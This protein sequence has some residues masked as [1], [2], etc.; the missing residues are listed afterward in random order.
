MLCKYAEI[1]ELRTYLVSHSAIEV[2]QNTSILYEY[3][4]TTPYIKNRDATGMCPMEELSQNKDNAEDLM[5]GIKK[6]F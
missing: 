5:I 2:L 4:K 6:F 1:K 3:N